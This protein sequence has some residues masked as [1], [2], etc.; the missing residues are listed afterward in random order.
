MEKVFTEKMGALVVPHN[1]SAHWTR[2]TVFKG[3]GNWD[4][5]VLGDEFQLEDLGA[6]P[7]V[8]KGINTGSSRRSDPLLLKGSGAQVPVPSQ[9]FG[10]V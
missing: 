9:S 5:G 6:W 10:S 4:V 7:F 1:H 3:L 2:P 8:G